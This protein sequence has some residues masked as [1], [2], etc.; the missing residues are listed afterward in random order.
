[1]VASRASLAA[2]VSRPPRAVRA[3]LGAL[4]PADWEKD[5]ENLFF[6]LVLGVFIFSRALSKEQKEQL[7]LRLEYELYKWGF[8]KYRD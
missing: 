6:L 4:P 8:I 3:L 5:M 2:G 7:R 1:M